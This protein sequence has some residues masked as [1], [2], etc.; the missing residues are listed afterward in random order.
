M[1]PRAGTEF[2][3]IPNLRIQSPK[4]ARSV[5][6]F[7]AVIFIVVEKIVIGAVALKNV[8]AHSFL[9]PELKLSSAGS[10]PSKRVLSSS[11]VYGPCFTSN[12]SSSSSTSK[13]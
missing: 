3:D 13:P 12:I 6:Y 11:P 10:F 8:V 4:G 1:S 2:E 9:P 7:M 5:L